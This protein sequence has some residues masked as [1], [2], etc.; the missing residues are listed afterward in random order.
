MGFSFTKLGFIEL[1]RAMGGRNYWCALDDALVS[2]S[3]LNL[4]QR[5]TQVLTMSTVHSALFVR[6]DISIS[7]TSDDAAVLTL[8]ECVFNEVVFSV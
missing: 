8:L 5:I 7:F 3:V 6:C 2:V 1:G 4:V